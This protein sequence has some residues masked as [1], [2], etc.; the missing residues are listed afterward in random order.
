[1]IAQTLRSIIQSN[2]RQTFHADPRFVFDVLL[3]TGSICEAVFNA[4]L[5]HRGHN[6]ERGSVY[7]SAFDFSLGGEQFF[8]IKATQASQ[9]GGNI[10]VERIQNTNNG[11]RPCHWEEELLEGVRYWMVFCDW[12]DRFAFYGYQVRPLRD[13][14]RNQAPIAGQGGAR[15]KGHIIRCDR[16]CWVYR[17]QAIHN[18]TLFQSLPDLAFAKLTK[19]LE[20]R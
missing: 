8:E 18:Q 7:G 19:E 4:A 12:T 9:F 6:L 20:K 16:A 5:A 15:G 10:F 2:T 11:S 14:L 1:M 3:E 13:W 17:P